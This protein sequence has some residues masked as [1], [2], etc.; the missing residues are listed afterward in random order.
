MFVKRNTGSSNKNEE[1]EI[2]DRVRK[3]P[4]T[5][6]PSPSGGRVYRGPKSGN[7]HQ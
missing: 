1:K 5:K 3:I 6:F 4:D 7:G 2:K